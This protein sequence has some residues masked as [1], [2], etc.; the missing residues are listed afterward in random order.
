D[1]YTLSL[2][3]ALPI[4]KPYTNNNN[5]YLNASLRRN[6]FDTRNIDIASY[7]DTV[8][9]KNIYSNEGSYLFSVKLKDGNHENIYTILQFFCWLLAWIALLIFFNSLCLHLAKT[10]RAWW[11]IT[12]LAGVFILVKFADLKWNLLSENATFAIFD[13][14]NY[15]YNSFFPNIWS[16][17]STTILILWWMVFIYSIRKELNF[18]KVKNIRLFKLPLAIGLILSIYL[19]FALLYDIAGTLVTHSNNIYFDFTKLVDLH[20]LSWVDLG[21][22]GLGILS[23]NIFIDLVLFFL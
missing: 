18:D 10:K 12:M 22:I 16:V 17:L 9:I 3:D 23:L 20:F 11:A 5:P 4:F 6:L 21:I 19:S 7:T 15:A 2:L 8:A 13:S 1:I 14:R